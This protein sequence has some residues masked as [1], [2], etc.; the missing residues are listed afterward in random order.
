MLGVGQF[1]SQ[2]AQVAELYNVEY[3]EVTLPIAGFDT[4]FLPDKVAGQK[5]SVISKGIRTVSRDGVISRDLGIVDSATR[6]GQLVVRVEDPYGFKSG[7]QQ[8]K[9]GSYAEVNFIGTTLENVYRL[10]QELV[11]NQVVW[12]VDGEQKLE[13]RTVAVLREEG[14]F[15]LV[16]DGLN[17]NDRI[18]TTLPE[19]PQKGMAVKLSDGINASS[20]SESGND[21][22][23]TL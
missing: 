4:A 20:G 23:A 8:L 19:Y 6:M 7:Q 2:G 3:A 22:A 16:R 21:A 9:F 5:A 14:E 10:P 15:Y 13:P 12:V 18:V 11:N 1:V 17:N